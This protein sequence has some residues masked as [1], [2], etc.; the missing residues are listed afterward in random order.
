MNVPGFVHL[1]G[2]GAQGFGL[3]R[4]CSS[5]PIPLIRKEPS[6][7]SLLA[8]DDFSHAIGVAINDTSGVERWRFTASRDGDDISWRLLREVASL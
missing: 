2:Q 6:N 8:G 4:S 7:K 5:N 1:Y 3:R